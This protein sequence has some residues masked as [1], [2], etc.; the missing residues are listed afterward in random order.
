VAQI[1]CVLDVDEAQLTEEM[2]LGMAKE[3]GRAFLQQLF[4]KICQRD[5]HSKLVRVEDFMVCARCQERI[6]ELAS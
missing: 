5:G 4:A 2:A 3:A 6:V 1:A